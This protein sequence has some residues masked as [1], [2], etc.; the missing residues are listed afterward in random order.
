MRGLRSC[1]KPL[2][3]GAFCVGWLPPAGR[4]AETLRLDGVTVSYTGISQPYAQAIGRTTAAARRIAVEQ[5]GFDMPGTITVVVTLDPNAKVR[6]FND[7]ADRF[8][9]TVRSERD[10]RQPRTSG[11]FHLYGLCHEVGHLA[12]YRPIRDRRWMTTAAAEGWAHYL[13]SRIVDAVHAR[14]GADLWPDRYDYLQDGT[15][16]LQ[17]QLASGQPGEVA[18]GA[19]LWKRLTEIV[20]DRGIAPIFRA[21]GEARFDPADPAAALG[22]ALLASQRDPRVAEWWKTAQSTL[23]LK[24][25]KSDFAARA[26]TQDQLLGRPRELVHDDGRQAGKKSIAGGGHA[27]RFQADGDSGCVTGVRIFGSRY[28]YPAPPQEDFHVWICDENFKTIAD[29]P[30]PYAKFKRGPPGWVT[31]RMK[32]TRV[33]AKFIVCVGFNPTGTKGVFVGRD[34]GG[35]GN[36][37]SGLPGRPGRPLAEGDWMIRATVDQLKASAGPQAAP[38]DGAPPAVARVDQLTG[39]PQELAHDNGRQAGKKSIAG[40]GHAVRF[41]ADGDS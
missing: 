26:I 19:G 22:K 8:S 24:R 17:K 2:V 6:L 38:P 41:Q 7:G 32:P 28:G 1:W 30:F 27:V 23:V 11:I 29:F 10:L 31:L 21:W 36:S 4:G 14:E 20:G 35:S 18:R 13:G 3:L 34:D 39:R 15:K 33:P 40:G 12:M 25:P 16:R 9:L 37:L 5:F